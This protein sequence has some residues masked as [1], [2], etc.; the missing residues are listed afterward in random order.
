VG[1]RIRETIQLLATFPMLGHEGVLLGA[2][3]MVVPGLPYVVVYRID[4]SGAG[5]SIVR[6]PGH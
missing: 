6:A 4:R 5:A 2:R 3:E 1:Q